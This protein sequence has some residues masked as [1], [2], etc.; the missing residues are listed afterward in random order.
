MTKLPENNGEQGSKSGLKQRLATVNVQGLRGV[1]SGRNSAGG[2]GASQ[3]TVR[4]SAEQQIMTMEPSAI[5]SGTDFRL[6]AAGPQIPIVE[7][8]PVYRTA[9]REAI[10]QNLTNTADRS[11]YF[12]L[13]GQLSAAPNFLPS[14]LR[15]ESQLTGTN[16][17]SSSPILDQSS[18]VFE[19]LVLPFKVTESASDGQGSD[20]G[21]IFTMLPSLNTAVTPALVSCLRSFALFGS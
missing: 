10:N 14:R 5:P 19:N 4:G 9:F 13:K 8:N 21:R 15:L 12:V 3:V 6:G 7:G 1:L 2:A 18:G 17:G 16:S 11:G 20:A